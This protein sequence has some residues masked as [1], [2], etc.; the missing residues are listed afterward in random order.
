MERAFFGFD[1]RVQ[2]PKNDFPWG[3][4]NWLHD[5][6]KENAD[7]GNRVG[8]WWKMTPWPIRNI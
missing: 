5:K 3:S 4:N 7:G 2:K 8:A 1:T 6:P